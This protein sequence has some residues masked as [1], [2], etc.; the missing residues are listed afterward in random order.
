MQSTAQDKAV[1]DLSITGNDRLLHLAGLLEA[2][3]EDDFNMSRWDRCAL[4]VASG[5]PWCQAQGFDLVGRGAPRYDGYKGFEAAAQFFG[6]SVAEARW[7][8]G[9]A[10]Y[11]HVPSPQEVAG[12]LRSYLH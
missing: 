12:R 9:G 3:Q 7:L 10:G 1:I 4:G 5:D 11:G 8:F 6:T 2:V